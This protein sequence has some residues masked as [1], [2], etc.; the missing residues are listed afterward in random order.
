MSVTCYS[1][2]SVTDEE[3]LRE[4]IVDLSTEITIK[5][6]LIDELEHSQRRLT[7]LKHQ[8]E[9]K[10]NLLQ[11]KIKETQEERDKVGYIFLF[12]FHSLLRTKLD[13]NSL[14]NTN[15]GNYMRHDVLDG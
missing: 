6:K 1:I 15:F 13:H 5:Q 8:Y 14:N 11:H 3:A 2:L 9:E 7:A 12:L 10:L 4:D